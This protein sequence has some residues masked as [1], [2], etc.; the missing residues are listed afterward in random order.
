[1]QRMGARYA[2]KEGTY[3]TQRLDGARSAPRPG[4]NDHDLRAKGLHGEQ[5]EDLQNRA[6]ANTKE[7]TEEPRHLDGILRD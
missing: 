5:D 7:E 1:M 4:V 6:E 3:R 2:V